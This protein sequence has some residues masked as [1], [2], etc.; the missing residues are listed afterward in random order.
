LWL[1][2]TNITNAPE[3][4]PDVFCPG[5]PANPGSSKSS[6]IILRDAPTAAVK[7]PKFH[8]YEEIEEFLSIL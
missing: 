2:R 8:F 7:K 1:F 3:K 5:F 4:L 6:L